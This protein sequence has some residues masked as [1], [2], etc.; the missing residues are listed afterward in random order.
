MSNSSV[1]GATILRNQTY[2]TKVLILGNILDYKTGMWSRSR[3]L[4][5]EAGAEVA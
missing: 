2:I 1:T 5:V 4:L 3:P